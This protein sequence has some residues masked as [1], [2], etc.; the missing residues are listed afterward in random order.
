LN[1]RNEVVERAIDQ[2]RHFGTLHTSIAAGRAQTGIGGEIIRRLENM[3]G[4]DSMARI[5]PTTFA[6]NCAT[7]GGISQMNCTVVMHPNLHATVQFAIRGAVAPDRIIKTRNTAEVAATY[8]QGSRRKVVVVEDGLYSMGRFADFESLSKFLTRCPNGLV[9]FDDA[10]SVGMRGRDGRGEAMEQMQAHTGQTIV[11]GSFGKAYGAVGG[12]MTA[13]ASFVRETLEVSVSDRFSC[14]LD[15][16]AQGA[17]L[18][19]MELLAN[20]A[21]NSTSIMKPTLF[22]ISSP[23]AANR[24]SKCLTVIWEALLCLRN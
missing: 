10:H 7:A 13:P 5:Y 11:T 24:P 4:P 19:A 6:A 17:I 1:L 16:S 2:I 22:T 21:S 18:G 23:K 14:N 8:A 12:F 3:K 20:Q 9:W 15:V